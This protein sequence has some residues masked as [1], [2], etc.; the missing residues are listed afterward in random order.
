[1]SAHNLRSCFLPV[2]LSGFGQRVSSYGRK[3][4]TPHIIALIFNNLTQNLRS[5]V[6]LRAS[7][8]IKKQAITNPK[9]Q[10][11]YA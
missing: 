1:M 11:R 4:I 2:K 6:L 7:E 3:K 10:F 9:H 5:A 8:Y